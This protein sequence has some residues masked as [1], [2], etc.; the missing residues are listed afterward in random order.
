MENLREFKKLWHDTFRD[1]R[2]WMDLYF[3]RYY[4]PD[5]AVMNIDNTS[6]R[7]VCQLLLVPYTMVLPG[8]HRVSVSYI[9]G[10]ATAHEMRGKGLMRSLLAD[11]LKLS[12]HRG[13]ILCT[14][15]PA[16]RRLYSFYERSGF[17]TVFYIDE[18]RYTSAHKFE[19]SGDYDL[20]TVTTSSAD[21]VKRFAD[22]W[23]A[24]AAKRECYVDHKVDEFDAIIGDT[25]LDNGIALLAKDSAGKDVGV[26]L[27]VE[28]EG[29]VTVRELLATDDD[30][31]EALLARLRH[32]HPAASFTVIAPVERTA[33]IESRGM[34]R[35]INAL[36]L[37]KVYAQRMTDAKHMTVRVHDSIIEENNRT[38]LLTPKDVSVIDADTA[39]VDLDVDVTVL[40]SILFSSKKAGDVFGFETHRPYISLMLD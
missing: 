25:L 22:C 38:F 24:L 15:I 31:A 10:A 23:R 26:A 33:P 37:L 2:E 19:P 32:Y 3:K 17:T 12:Y 13:D 35:V 11:A 8:G 4:T 36:E 28:H 29:S 9:S 7:S 18:Q 27:A 30:V 16:Y 1:T 6:G 34:V 20:T 5:S 39:H 21:Q 14:L 40:A